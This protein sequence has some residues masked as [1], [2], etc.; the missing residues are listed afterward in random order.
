M[1]IIGEFGRPIVL[2]IESRIH[3]LGL[4]GQEVATFLLDCTDVEY[5][6]WWPGVHLQ[7]HRRAAGGT[8][9]V[10]DVVFMD[11]LIGSRHV[12]MAAVVVE[13]EPAKK[14]VWQMKKGIRLPVRLSLELTDR[15]GGV[16][17]RHTI[18]A[19][20]SGVGRL[21]DPLF[22][23]YFSPRFAV[24]MDK[25]VRTEFPLLRDRLHTAA[26]EA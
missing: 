9:H 6:E 16:T 4:T 20:W 19:G 22:R 3:V 11:E 18:T 5:R 25:H 21:F 23:R 26:R 12:R 1:G 10:G 17:I 2:T 14:L 24:A 15:D 8:D 13:A 7:F